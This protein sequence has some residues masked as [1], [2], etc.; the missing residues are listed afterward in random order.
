MDTIPTLRSTIQLFIINFS[1]QI[2]PIYSAQLKPPLISDQPY[3][4]WEYE[5]LT[6]TPIIRGPSNGIA[7]MPSLALR[8]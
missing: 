3:T 1:R 7:Y 8:E 6:Y 5:V 2:P 4:H